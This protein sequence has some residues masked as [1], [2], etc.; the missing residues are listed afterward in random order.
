MVKSGLRGRFDMGDAA[1]GDTDLSRL[2]TIEVPSLLSLAGDGDRGGS[3]LTTAL[4]FFL[5]TDFVPS[6]TRPTSVFPF[7]LSWHQ[8]IQGYS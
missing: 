1:P 7:Q 4:F 3:P 2:W 6:N 8:D 5:A